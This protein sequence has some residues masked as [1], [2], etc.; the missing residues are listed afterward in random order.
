MSK[1]N[2]YEILGKDTKIGSV[3]PSIKQNLQMFVKRNYS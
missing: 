2:Y 1:S 3:Y